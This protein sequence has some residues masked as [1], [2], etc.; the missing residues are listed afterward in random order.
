MIRICAHTSHHQKSYCNSYCKCVCHSTWT[1]QSPNLLQE[2]LGGVFVG[3]SGYPFYNITQRYTE[4]GCLAQRKFFTSVHYQFPG[5]FLEKAV[6]ISVISMCDTIR[7]SLTIR[8]ILPHNAEIFRLV[9]LGDVNSL[10]SLFGMGLASPNDSTLDG[11][12]A[13]HVGYLFS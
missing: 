3:Y 9:Q 2:I 12:T 13:L 4:I 7:A 6:T 11:Q 10:K 1:F 8:R 5:W